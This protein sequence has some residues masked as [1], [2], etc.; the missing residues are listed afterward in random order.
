MVL[1]I[2]IVLMLSMFP[3]L[4]ALSGSLYSAVPFMGRYFGPIQ[5]L[6]F[7]FPVVLYFLWNNRS[8]LSLRLKKALVIGLVLL[9]FGTLTGGLGCGFP[10]EVVR[11][12]AIFILGIGSALALMLFPE[13]IFRKTIWAWI[14]IVYASVA[15]NVFWPA[16][17]NFLNMHFF[18]PI[19]R[20]P[21]WGEGNIK[22]LMGFYD[23]ASLGKLLA[24]LPWLAFWTFFVGR[25]ETKVHRAVPWLFLFGIVL[26]MALV[27]GTT[28][29]GPLL[30][31]IVGLAGFLLHRRFKVKDL[32]MF[33]WGAV[34][35]GIGIL[36]L[37][38]LVPKPILQARILELLQPS[39][40]SEE[41]A[42]AS[43]LAVI[44]R[45]RLWKIAG[46]SVIEHPLGRWCIPPQEYEQGGAINGAQHSHNLFLEQFVSRGWLWGL[47]HIGAWVYA[48]WT[49]WNRKRLADSA[50]LGGIATTL[51]LGLVDHPWFVI[52]HALI[53]G[54][55]LLGGLRSPEPGPVESA[56]HGFKPDQKT[57]G[58]R[59]AS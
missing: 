25:D 51:G 43:R 37:P 47:F 24:W 31:L 52:N 38:I 14:A 57:R 34:T 2:A 46:K 13:G 17:L 33:H 11:E 23:N 42:N 30:G 26:S 27:L 6:K 15:L 32:R 56:N 41:N 55:L 9:L 7:L 10:P 36:L 12:S 19:R 44:G 28:Q 29:R 54:T 58:A 8:R 21:I 5:P 3:S 18:D 20:V 53:L 22:F 40:N 50:L 59:P 49:T 4:T 45:V 16:G 39:Q 35:A 48:L 1:L